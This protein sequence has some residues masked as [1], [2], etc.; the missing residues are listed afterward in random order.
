MTLALIPVALVLLVV[1]SIRAEHIDVVGLGFA[2]L[3]GGD[4]VRRLTRRSDLSEA[5]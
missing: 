1:A 4:P 3:T 2:S 5:L